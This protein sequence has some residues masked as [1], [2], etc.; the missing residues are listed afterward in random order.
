MQVTFNRFLIRALLKKKMSLNIS[1]NSTTNET[2]TELVKESSKGK[3]YFTIDKLF[4]CLS[5]LVVIGI[6][7]AGNISV[8]LIIKRT[9]SL[10]TAQNYLLANLA[11][12]DVTSLLF[13]GFSLIPMVKVLPDGVV[14]TVLCMFFVG[15]N[16]PLTATVVSV[17]TLTILAIERYNAVAR[18][19]RMLQLTRETVRYAIIGTW[20]ASVALNTPLFVYTNYKFKTAACRQTY[21][22]HAELT[23]IIFYI[24]FVFTLPFIVISFCYSKLVKALNHRS[25]V[26]PDSNIPEKELIRQRKQLLKMSLTV[27]L[28]FGACVLPA[29][30]ATALRYFRLVSQTVRA[31]G[32]LLLFISSVVNPFIYAFH[33]SNYRRAFKTLLKCK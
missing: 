5:V 13:C 16:V 26:T 23:H 24:I 1:R 29:S 32:L 19:L 21:S 9:Q 12:A 10:Q 2:I 28:V 14:G 3:L 7:I 15:F 8:L 17:F 20:M 33:S 6:G 11:A 25:A 31:F 18:P 22:E 4:I 27:T 30:V